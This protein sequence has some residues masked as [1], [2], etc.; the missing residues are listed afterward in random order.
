MHYRTGPYVSELALGTMTFG[1]GPFRAA[2]DAG[3]DLFDTA[4][5]CAGG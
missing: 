1:G 5:V 2:F 3:I 4:D